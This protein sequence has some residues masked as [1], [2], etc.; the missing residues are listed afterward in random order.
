[1]DSAEPEQATSSL[2][3][4]RASTVADP[5][6]Q[7]EYSSA[8]SS[9]ME[10]WNPVGATAVTAPLSAITAAEVGTAEA[11]TFAP[12]QVLRS[13][14]LSTPAVATVPTVRPV[15]NSRYAAA[16]VVRGAT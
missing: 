1:M 13:T 5:A 7:A 12:P 9:S 4:R 16:T 10:T 14:A 11:S 2:A 3:A 6:G 8:I 15:P